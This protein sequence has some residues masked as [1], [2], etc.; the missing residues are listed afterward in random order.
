MND[1]GVAATTRGGGAAEHI[2]RW[3]TPAR[4]I[5]GELRSSSRDD[6]RAREQSCT[7]PISGAL[8]LPFAICPSDGASAA[9]RTAHAG[10]DIGPWMGSGPWVG[11]VGEAM[12]SRTMGSGSEM[13]AR[14]SRRKIMRQCDIG[15][16]NKKRDI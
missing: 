10:H 11:Q 6:T 4:W 14:D 13:E 3:H 8:E 9:T 5:Q 12:V 15:E 7:R 16:R 2:Q 1:L